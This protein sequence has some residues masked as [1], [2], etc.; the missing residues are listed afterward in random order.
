MRALS[1][2]VT[3][4][5]A[6]TASAAAQ[7]TPT[8]P[9]S[10][11]PVTP[12]APPA[13]TDPAVDPTA[14]PLP[15]DGVGPET[16]VLESAAPAE[17]ASSV[18]FGRDELA[19]RPHTRPSDL[20]RQTPG[21][22]VSQHAGGG[23]SDQYFLRGFDADH[24]TDVAL[25]VDG[26]P[27]NLTSHGHGQGY[28]D[29]H[30]LIPELV[31]SIDVHK[32]PYAARFGDFTTAGAIELRT[33][34]PAPGARV[35][36]TG[37]TQ[38]T[39]PVALRQPTSR[40][41]G[42]VA[43]RLARGSAVIAAEVGYADGP[44]LAPQGFGH[45][46]LMSKLRHRLAGGEA[47]AAVNLYAARWDQS[48]QLPAAEV[49]AGRLPRFGSLDP[50]EG[51]DTR[52]ASLA[53]GW[54]RGAPADGAWDVSAY[55]VHYR[56]QLFSN[57][58][59]FARDQ[60]HGDQIEQ[61][62]DRVMLGAAADY[63]RTHGRG[64]RAGLVR[65]GVQLR[66]DSTIADLWH[67]E[68]RARLAD[69]WAVANP[70]NRAR[71]RVVDVGAFVEEDLS[72][73]RRLRLLASLRADG[74]VWRV[75]DLD[76]ET[77]GTMASAGGGAHAA[78]VSPKLTAIVAASDELDVFVNA[79]LGFHS[80][81]ARAAVA[82]GGEGALARAIGGEVGA[83]L[84][85]GRELRGSLA[86][87]YLRLASEQVWSGDLGGTEPS[88]PTRRDGLDLELSWRP[89]P[90]LTVDGNVAV[91][92]SMFVANRGNGGALAL[93]PRIM[94]GG[95]V[96]VRHGASLAAVRLRGIGDRP[97]SDDGTL[98]ARGHLLVDVVAQRPLGGGA[99]LG[100]SVENLLDADWREAQFAEESR[101]TPTA[102]LVEDVHFTPGAPL[103]ALVT[104]EQRL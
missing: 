18:H 69:C 89:L 54:S 12:P 76:P 47:R 103:T 23:K 24:G 27:V 39:G 80:N 74:F 56:L 38:L 91:G 93:A 85:T 97:A 32:G 7:P 40:L 8:T 66:A 49:E 61:N 16:I 22:V 37:G 84:D 41:V 99:T 6:P 1:A 43:P 35:W 81:D 71:N 53:V 68:Q 30:W 4:V 10:P 13:A 50:S 70:C 88:D 55:A 94:G 90:W 59:L 34:E 100:L 104:L 33:I 11:P 62:D 57:F 79:G 20:L 72:L 31:D 45:L 60:V 58:T 75:E 87:W 98:T 26:V 15:D 83:R 19:A 82:S 48:G 95:G 42:M 36:L 2:F 86:L 5:L 73:G 25:F 67:A 64:A 78:I 9:P 77:A 92:R 51:G 52:R 46:H 63:R 102:S 29:S 65:A 21:L 28:A 96:T 3:V 17:A 101:V 14:E 44:F